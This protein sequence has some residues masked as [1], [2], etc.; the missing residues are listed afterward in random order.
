MIIFVFISFAIFIGSMVY[1]AFQTDVNLVQ[2]D[3]Y[4]NSTMHDQHVSDIK[5]SDNVEL[6]LFFDRSQNSVILETPENFE[7]SKVTGEVHFYRP[8]DG[9][10]DFNVPINLIENKQLF[11]VDELIT[12]KWIAKVSFTFEN[13]NFFKESSFSK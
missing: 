8:S 3:Y 6:K 2:D 13:E 1:Q 5:R 9:K 11:N 7:D 10:L 12:G 4:Q